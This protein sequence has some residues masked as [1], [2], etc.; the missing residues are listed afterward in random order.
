MNKPQITVALPSFNQGKF[1][2]QAL[3]SLDN[4]GINLEIFVVDGGSTDNTLKVLEKWQPK[5]A[6]WRSHPDDGQAAAINEAIAQG[7]APY[8]CWLNSDDW[9]LPGCFRLLIEALQKNPGSP[10]AYGKAWNIEETTAK[11][12]EVWVEPFNEKRLAK[13]CIISQPATLI[14]RHAW[15]KINGVDG[16]LHMAMD[17][18]LWWRIYKNCGPLVMIDEFVAVNRDH[19]TTKTNTKR[20]LHY[21]E[22]MDIVKKYYGKL[23][24]KWW[25]Y[26]PYA[27]WY[28][29]LMNQLRS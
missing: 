24:L 12:T 11:C 10:A 7:S 6:G 3:E 22:A 2:E 9:L 19:N 23:P 25:L 20:F 5:L 28:K 1:I 4:Q 8:V 13:R 14:R 26:Q 21:K 17:Y 29:T 18:D 16:N 27:V 15:E